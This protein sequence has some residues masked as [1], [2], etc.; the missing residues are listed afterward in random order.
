MGI[1]RK[2]LEQRA[3]ECPRVVRIGLIVLLVVVVTAMCASVALAADEEAPRV[4]GPESI[5]GA[6]V[7]LIDGQSYL[8]DARG[9]T[10]NVGI[11]KYRWEIYDPSGTTSNVSSTTPTKSWTPPG[12][13]LY[14]VISWAYDA[15]DNEGAY[16][17]V[18]D[19]V[20]VVTAQTIRDAS[21]TYDHSIMVDSGQLSYNNCDIDFTGGLERD[22]P[23]LPTGEMLTEG[24]TF[25]G[26][27]DGSLAGSWGPYSSNYG[28]VYEETDRVLVGNKAI[29]NT[30]GTNYGFTY[31]F[32]NVE[33]L[34]IYNSFHAWFLKDFFNGRFYYLEFYDASGSYLRVQPCTQTNNVAGP[35]FGVSV[36]LDLENVGRIINYGL[37]DLTS[38]KEFKVRFYGQRYAIIMDGMYFSRKAPLDNMTESATPGGAFGGTWVGLTTGNQ[39]Y[40]GSHSAVFKV[41]AL[42]Q[43]F[44][45]EYIWTNPVKLS[46]Y[47]AA[48]FFV[49]YETGVANGGYS[50]MRTLVF[51]DADGDYATNSA[52][53]LPYLQS[54]ETDRYG[55][56]SQTNLPMDKTAYTETGTMDWTRVKSMKF[57]V[58]AQRPGDL[59]FD[60]LEWY[61]SKR[62]TPGTPGL[63]ENLAHGIYVGNA[64]TLAL[65]TVDFDPSG[66]YGGFI[67]AEGDLSISG[68]TFSN[69]WGT[70]HPSI[71]LE[72]S[73]WGGI[74]AIGSDVT[75]DTVSVDGA[76][77]CAVT[78]VNCDVA[79]KDLVVTGAG[80]DFEG[81]VAI[82]II[83][84]G[85]DAGDTND[86]SLRGCTFTDTSM[87]T[88]LLVY[89]GD[90]PGDVAGTIEDVTASD[91]AGHGI[92]LTVEREVGTIDI[93]VSYTDVTGNGGTGLMTTSSNVDNTLSYIQYSLRGILASG[94]AGDGIAS[95]VEMSQIDLALTL[96]DVSSSNNAGDGFSLNIADSSG[97][98]MVDA[99]NVTLADNSGNGMEM[100]VG[101]KPYSFGGDTVNPD[102][103]LGLELD[104]CELTGNNG[105]GMYEYWSTGVTISFPP[106]PKHTYTMHAVDVSLSDNRGAGYTITEDAL[107]T[108]RV[109][110]YTFEDSLLD[111]NDGCG[112]QLME[113][114][115][116]RATAI[117]TFSFVNCSLSGNLKGLEQQITSAFSSV[118]S[119]QGCVFANNDQEAIHGHTLA[120]TYRYSLVEYYV[121]G[122]DVD[123]PMSFNLDGAMMEPAIS[124][125]N[126]LGAT[127]SVRDCTLRSEYPLQVLAR[128][129]YK[130]TWKS[131]YL[132]I[133]EAKLYFTGNTMTVPSRSDG[134]RAEL[135]GSAVLEADVVIKDV[136]FDTPGNDGI[137][138]VLGSGAT[139]PD[140]QRVVYGSVEVSNVTI[141]DPG[142]NGIMVSTATVNDMIA[143]RG[144]LC[145]LTDVTVTGAV[146]GMK[147]DGIDTEVRRCT[148]AEIA[149]TTVFAREC[150]VDLRSSDYGVIQEPNIRAQDAGMVRMWFDLHV[151]VKWT[152]SDD[153][154]IGARVELIDNA[155]QTSGF[156]EVTG[157]EPMGFL[158]LNSITIMEAGT[159]IKNPYRLSTSFLDLA[160]EMYLDIN[161][162]TT[163]TVWLVDDIPPI[164]SLHLPEDGSSQ[165]SDSILVDGT[166]YDLHRTV[167]KV[168]V[169]I[170]GET[171]LDAEGT[172]SFTCTVPDVPDGTVVVRVRVYDTGGNRKEVIA[173]VH[174]DTTPPVLVVVSPRDGLVTNEPTVKVLAA[175]ETGAVAYVNQVPAEVEF[176]LIEE[177]VDLAEGVNSIEISVIDAL[178]NT[179]QVLV[180]V[181]LDTMVPHLSVTSHEDW[182]SVSSPSID[183]AGMT[184]PSGVTVHVNG[185][186]VD[187]S[188]SGR[189]ETTIDLDPGRN[190][191]RLQAVDVAGNVH[192][193]I[194]TVF[195]DQEAPALTVLSPVPGEFIGGSQVRVV[196]LVEPGCTVLV[197]GQQV[198]EENGQV[199]TL[200]SLMDGSHTLTVVAMDAAGNRRTVEVP[201]TV[202]TAPPSLTI[203]SPADGAITSGDKASVSGTTSVDGASLVSVTVNGVAVQVGQDGSFGTEVDLMEGSNLVV[204]R[205]VDEAGNVLEAKR[206]VVRDSMAPFLDFDIPDAKLTVSGI[207]QV[208]T[209]R[210]M[211]TGFGELGTTVW[212]N[213]IA[214][215][216]DPET[217]FFSVQLDTRDAEGP[218][219]D[220]NI[221]AV[222]GAGNTSEGTATVKKVAAEEDTDDVGS[223]GWVIL[224]IGLLLVLVGIY[225]LVRYRSAPVDDDEGPEVMDR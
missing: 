192:A 45:I 184:E 178:G 119:F 46:T 69:L 67:R 29:V 221:L 21:L 174:V 17:Y 193:L 73:T 94:N 137:N 33:D 162:D 150:I 196:A 49:W 222:D 224:V 126:T 181:T 65:T 23:S 72:G 167:D 102:I 204:V 18:I 142:R 86:F 20:E 158:D 19:V 78:T 145:R 8:L 30:G 59:C 55:Q 138:L 11:T 53:A 85:T 205:A 32:D 79:V 64:A 38:V 175:T 139:L 194:F 151:Q 209:S 84:M 60:G 214:V 110:D 134:L 113:D 68:S 106:Y 70:M 210:F 40:V 172:E 177:W 132:Y 98:V 182:A 207:H 10:D 95:I 153:A 7:I 99:N 169:S 155:Y 12:P 36:S 149:V 5:P 109:A 154:V 160:Q 118:F 43:I 74:V 148:F 223:M 56:W 218:T 189:F 4:S 212:V 147:M 100:L 200:V 216:M 13:G 103:V 28:S 104:G 187:V 15:E 96:Q 25:S 26:L 120:A 156:S 58:Q 115:Y 111:D 128:A 75:I 143:L 164:V 39:A 16:V 1:G 133:F 76:S 62:F 51:T 173:S 141:T 52:T 90:A 188:D 6:D 24:L 117:N 54:Y 3:G 165:S 152:G 112:L 114:V 123:G 71:P 131:P 81:A 217:G 14:K 35:W 180:N 179:R 77:S 211:V 34:T 225:L 144:V 213:G 61:R 136:V 129:Q 176:T 57:E 87:G 202:D 190:D 219:L 203:A 2:E 183:L 124:E 22:P 41:T 140:H 220:I 121:H 199:D 105:N 50:R 91:N 195:L 37:T 168:Q 186:L 130:S 208:T 83:Y 127:I 191:I 198:T 122:C 116:L 93:D 44:D 82:A 197:G 159:F 135:W 47:N 88:G 66:P 125:R 170:D 97:A 108:E 63:T 27:S 42:G 163:T 146:V 107:A 171:W 101:L 166:A 157:T 92:R 80:N 161:G 215:D 31:T 201:I 9:S 185:A 89:V 206:T 48:R